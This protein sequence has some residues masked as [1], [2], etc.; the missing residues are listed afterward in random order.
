MYG[1][2]FAICKFPSLGVIWTHFLSD[3]GTSSYKSS[4]DHLCNIWKLWLFL[5]FIGLFLSL[6]SWPFNLQQYRFSFSAEKMR[7]RL[8]QK[9]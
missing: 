8:E 1:V 3:G 6:F 2:A 9:V 7:E 5:D 4:G